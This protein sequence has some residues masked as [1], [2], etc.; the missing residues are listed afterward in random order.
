MCIKSS[1]CADTA[2]DAKDGL[3][4]KGGFD[5]TPLENGQIVEMSN[6]VALE[7]ETDPV[8]LTKVFQDPFDVGPGV[9]EDVVARGLWIYGFPFVFE[10]LDAGG[11]L[12]RAK[13][14]EP[15]LS[16]H[17]SGERRRAAAVR[18]SSVIPDSRRR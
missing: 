12:V 1:G 3:H 4:E 13:F 11:H 5:Q 8:A 17:I 9:A 18:A 7:F 14:M 2:E 10:F 16:E 6:V 15:I